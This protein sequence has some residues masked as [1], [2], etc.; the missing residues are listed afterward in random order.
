MVTV[1]VLQSTLV[2]DQG[3]QV[4]EISIQVYIL[5]I[6][7]AGCIPAV[8]GILQIYYDSEWICYLDNALKRFLS[9]L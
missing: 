5:G 3:S 6:V 7:T 2:V 8:Y 9:I 4:G 1:K